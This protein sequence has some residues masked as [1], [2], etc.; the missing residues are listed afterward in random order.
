MIHCVNVTFSQHSAKSTKPGIEEDA[1]SHTKANRRSHEDQRKTS[2]PYMTFIRLRRDNN[3]DNT[4]HTKFTFGS[5]N[6]K[7]KYGA[8]RKSR[9]SIATRSASDCRDRDSNS[10]RIAISNR[11]R[12]C[13]Y[14]NI[15][16]LDR[17]SRLRRNVSRV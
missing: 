8:L 12:D 2:V 16:T 5:D 4:L 14:R 11:S 15:E 1:T 13:N 6:R 7:E 9:K 17:D 10:A 3:R